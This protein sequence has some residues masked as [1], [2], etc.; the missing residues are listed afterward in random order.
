MMEVKGVNPETGEEYQ[1]QSE[2]IDNKF[3]KYLRDF[4]VSDDDIRRL[5]DKL[6]ISADAKSLL[7]SFSKTTIKIGENIVKVG[8][9]IIDIIFTMLKEFPS[10]TFGI[11]FGAT[12]GLLISS[13][14]V[15]GVVLGPIFTP[16]AIAIGLAV[17]LVE[18]IKD[19]NLVRKIKQQAATFSPLNA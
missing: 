19:K 9:K 7:F 5:I 2:Q 10:A 18:D 6:D 16:I 17:G 8:K 1:S 15:L 4:S 14:P 3:L 12:V 11:I 13:I